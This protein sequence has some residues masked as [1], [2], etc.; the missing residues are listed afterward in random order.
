MYTIYD[1]TSDRFLI[2]RSDGILLCFWSVP[3]LGALPSCVS[4][5]SPSTVSNPNPV[6][7]K[8]AP[9]TMKAGS[10]NA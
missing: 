2:Y 6:S 3:E 8:Q 1:Y 10:L 9:K 5:V 7:P 4:L